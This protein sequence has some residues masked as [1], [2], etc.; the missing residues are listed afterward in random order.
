MS[1][2]ILT[3]FL[4][5]VGNSWKEGK[6]ISEQQD[7]LCMVSGESNLDS[8]RSSCGLGVPVK[9]T[10]F[11]RRGG[12]CFTDCQFMTSSR[13]WEDKVS[14]MP[15]PLQPAYVVSIYFSNEFSWHFPSGTL[16]LKQTWQKLCL[17]GQP[18]R[19]KMSSMCYMSP[20]IGSASAWHSEWVRAMAI[21]LILTI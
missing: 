15:L 17:Q 12:M 4:W 5:A 10:Y 8:Q 16:L 21:S 14:W 3:S 9:R 13:A 18:H 20:S 19:N 1:L 7:S 2:F 6:K 11:P